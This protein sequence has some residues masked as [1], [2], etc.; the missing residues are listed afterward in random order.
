[1]QWKIDKKS[2]WNW[3]GGRSTE[4]ILFLLL[5]LPMLLLCFVYK[6]LNEFSMP[7]LCLLFI[8][9]LFSLKHA[10]VSLFFVK[11]EKCV[12]IKNTRKTENF[13]F[14]IVLRKS[15][16]Q[17]N[18]YFPSQNDSSLILKG[19]TRTGKDAEVWL[20]FCIHLL[21]QSHIFMHMCVFFF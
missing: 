10:C 17:W 12:R 7:L 1:M 20:S 14:V 15:V 8:L 13:F 19:R 6:F 18:H 21:H 5:L 2:T 4:Q 9:H 11:Q 16:W 3:K